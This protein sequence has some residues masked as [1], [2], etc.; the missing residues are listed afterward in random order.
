M[1]IAKLVLEFMKVLTWP[2]VVLVIIFLF[3]PYL[4]RILRQFSDRLGSAET[5]KLGVLGQEV[6]ISGTAKELAKERVLLAQSSDP[7]E[8]TDKLQLVDQATRELNNPFADLVGLKL[9][10]TDGGIRLE[11]LVHAVV[12]AMSPGGSQPEQ[13]PMVILAMTREVNKILAQLQNLGYANVKKDEYALTP[14]GRS[15]FK[16]VAEQQ[17]EFL[18]RYNAL[19]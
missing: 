12:R 15:F 9:L 3:R 1:E 5:L 17:G 11:N 10:N 18:A 19:K 13:P 8:S 6:Q 7:R 16:R 14:A 4:E 2:V